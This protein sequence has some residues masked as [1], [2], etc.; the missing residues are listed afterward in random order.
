MYKQKFHEIQSELSISRMMEKELSADIEALQKKYDLDQAAAV[1]REKDLEEKFSLTVKE[2]SEK[3]TIKNN[4]I[5][6]LF[7]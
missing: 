7:Y 2:L 6:V 1:L 4:I 3:V 5:I